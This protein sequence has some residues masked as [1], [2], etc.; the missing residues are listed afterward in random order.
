MMFPVDKNDVL[1]VLDNYGIPVDD[2]DKGTVMEVIDDDSI[3][4]V[5]GDA[6]AEGLNNEQVQEVFYDEIARQLFQSGYIPKENVL[7]YG[8]PNIM[9]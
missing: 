1:L 6:N 3:E 9:I 7:K 8:N 4:R 5:C 2:L